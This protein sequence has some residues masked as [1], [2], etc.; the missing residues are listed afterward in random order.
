MAEVFPKVVT[1]KE[2]EGGQRL[3]ER[4]SQ[5]QTLLKQE[6]RK[7]HETQLGP[8]STA[9]LPDAL[10]ITTGAEGKWKL[11]IGAKKQLDCCPIKSH[12]GTSCIGM[13]QGNWKM[14]DLLRKPYLFYSYIHSAKLKNVFTSFNLSQFIMLELNSMFLW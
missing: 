2:V 7:R 13:T 9:H 1:G 10:T 11:Q 6:T 14:K 3:E 5:H 12:K 4:A 8:D